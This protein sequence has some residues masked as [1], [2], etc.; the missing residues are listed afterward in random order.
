MAQQH[1]LVKTGP[2]APQNYI[3]DKVQ[4]KPFAADLGTRWEWGLAFQRQSESSFLTFLMELVLKRTML[5]A[6]LTHSLPNPQF[7]IGIDDWSRWSQDALVK[8]NDFAH[9]CAQVISTRQ[10]AAQEQEDLAVF[11]A[12]NLFA[13]SHVHETWAEDAYYPDEKV[14]AE[15]STL[16]PAQMG[17][18]SVTVRHQLPLVGKHW[19]VETQQ[20]VAENVSPYSVLKLIFR[21]TKLPSSDEVQRHP[22]EYKDLPARENIFVPMPLD[23]SAKE[24]AKYFVAHWWKSK[25]AGNKKEKPKIYTWMANIVRAMAICDGV[26]ENWLYHIGPSIDENFVAAS[27]RP[28]AAQRQNFPGRARV[29]RVQAI[30]DEKESL[31]GFRNKW[32]TEGAVAAAISWA[33]ETAQEQKARFEKENTWRSERA[34]KLYLKYAE[35]DVFMSQLEDKVQLEDGNWKLTVWVM[36][37][38]IQEQRFSAATATTDKWTFCSAVADYL[39]Y[40]WPEEEFDLLPKDGAIVFEK[41]AG[42]DG[43]YP[44]ELSSEGGT[45]MERLHW[46]QTKWK[47]WLLQVAEKR[48]EQKLHEEELAW[49][50]QVVFWI[51]VLITEDEKPKKDEAETQQ[52]KAKKQ[53]KEQTDDEE[54]ERATLWQAFVS[55]PTRGLPSRFLN[56]LAK[57]EGLETER[58]M[59]KKILEMMGGRI[60]AIKAIG[61]TVPRSVEVVIKEGMFFDIKKK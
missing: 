32:N 49:R 39:L 46:R 41:A 1:W 58:D 23:N 31:I 34:K 47:P 38:P 61:E 51:Y 37:E 5:C 56:D 11:A 2:F 19:V 9:E 12:D 45:E 26:N 21:G 25:Y 7:A 20:E 52:P 28:A 33:K 35:D 22:T 16:E 43:F 55:D 3:L 18:Q 50:A 53:R 17:A 36:T 44:V 14:Q 42:R 57:I 27:A 8:C 24:T 29:A 6:S 60:E 48:V 13:N 4:T 59:R 54:N 10:D 15:L 30:Q 40:E